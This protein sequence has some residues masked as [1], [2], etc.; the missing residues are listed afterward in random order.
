MNETRLPFTMKATA[1]FDDPQ[2][3]YSHDPLP[4]GWVRLPVSFQ[5]T[6]PS[7]VMQHVGRG[8]SPSIGP[9]EEAHGERKERSSLVPPDAG[10]LS[11]GQQAN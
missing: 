2:A 8:S 11:E 6:L 3:E 7:D 10:P 9:G 1:N 4:P 5:I